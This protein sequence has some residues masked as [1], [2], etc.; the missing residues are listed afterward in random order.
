MTVTIDQ[1]E[2]LSKQIADKRAEIDI[3]SLERKKKDAELSE[4][5]SKMML[6]L[7]EAGKH[8]YHAEC[9]TVYITERVSVKVPKDLDEKRKLFG[10]LRE[11]GIFEELV[12]VNSQTLNAYYKAE[13]KL[14][15]EAGNP[16]FELPGV[17][18]PTVDQILAFR[19]A[20]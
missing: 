3:I 20:K 2:S 17:G 5:E 6:T 10:Y 15:E 18:E 4:L 16:F 14:A 11:K 1:L 19:K 13:R 12:S 9:G 8:D 7:E